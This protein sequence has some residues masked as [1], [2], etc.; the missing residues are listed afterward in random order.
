[1]L[2]FL[3]A[4]GLALSPP[5]SA[6]I[7][8]E[9]PDAIVCSVKDPTGFLPWEQLV[10]YVSAHTVDGDTLY[11]TLTSDPIVLLVSA[12]GIIQGANLADCDGRTIASLLEEGRAFSLTV[13]AAARDSE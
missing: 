10:F 5:A 1:M 11:K 3:L 7:I 2:N 13:P 4:A 8:D 12:E 9:L 6:G